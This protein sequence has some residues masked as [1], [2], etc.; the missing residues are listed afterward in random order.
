MIEEL[1][2]RGNQSGL[3]VASSGYQKYEP[4]P[5]M[6]EFLSGAKDEVNLD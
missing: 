4:K 1:L 6:Q 3:Q 2:S 5:I